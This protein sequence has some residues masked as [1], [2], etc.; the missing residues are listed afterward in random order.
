[1][2]M[3]K[4][5]VTSKFAGQLTLVSQIDGI[6]NE[7]LKKDESKIL[8]FGQLAAFDKSLIAFQNSEM[9][10]LEKIAEELEPAAKKELS[11]IREKLAKLKGEYNSTDTTKERKIAIKIE[12]KDLQAEAEAL[13]Q[14]TVETLEENEIENENLP[15]DPETPVKPEETEQSGEPA[16]TVA[17]TAA[18]SQG[19]ADSQSA[20]E[21]PAGDSKDADPESDEDSEE[22]SDKQ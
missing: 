1:M 14:K 2:A 20:D 7:V 15:E 18:Q 19:D 9:I 17:P 11:K 16:A 8:N 4:G 12:V 21:E 22:E 10:V 6:P 13:K 5:K 3:N